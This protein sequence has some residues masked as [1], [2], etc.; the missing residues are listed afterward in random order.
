MKRITT[1]LFL[2]GL[3]CIP[4]RS[5]E[6]KLLRQPDINQNQVVFVYASDLWTVPAA[7]GIATRL[8]SHRGME[9][10]PKISPDG[11]W[12]AFSGEYN[13]SRQIFVIPSHGGL[14]RQLT[15][16][17]DVGPMPPRG[18]W[19]HI[20]LDWTPDSRQVL[21]RANRTPYGKRNG[22]YYLVSINGGL[23]TPLEIPEGG[24][25]GFSPE[26]N[27]ICYTPISREFRTWK[28]YRGGRA[29]D[30][31]TY[32][33]E[34]HRSRRLTTFTGS[35]QTPVWMGDKIYYCSDQDTRLNVF[36]FDI[37][38]GETRQLTRH[39]EFDCLWLSGQKGQLVYE[40]GGEIYRLEL[41]TGKNQK[42]PV[43][44]HTDN[45]LLLPRHQNVRKNIYSYQLSPTG[46]RALM[47]ARGDIYTVPA[48]H[49]VI[50]NLT[51]S[52]GIREI[53]PV[54]SPD[55]KHIAYYSDASGEYELYLKSVFADRTTQITRESTGWKNPPRWSPDSRYLLYSDRTLHLKYLEVESR[56]EKMIDRAWGHPI[57]DYR[58]SPDS[59][60]ITYAKD[61]PNGNDSLYIYSLEKGETHRVTTDEF[62]EHD[63]L[64]SRDGRYLFFLSQ[65]DFNL[66][67]SSYEFDYLYHDA[68]A[69]YY[70]PLT[71]TT[72]SLFPDR[73]D[74]ES[75]EKPSPE[76]KT[77]KVRLD[78]AG[79]CRRIGKF[80]LG[81]G[82][83]HSLAAVENGLL[84][85]KD[86]N[87]KKYDLNQ[88]KELD[89]LSGIQGYEPS[90]DG[91]K[92]LYSFAG[93]G[94][95]I[96][97]LD[98]GQQ[99]HP[100]ELDLEQMVMDIDPAR[101]W[102]QIFMDCWRIFRDWFYVQNLHN[103]NW[104]AVRDKY[105]ALVPYLGHRADL[106]F[107][108]GEMMAESNTGHCYVNWGD[109]PEIRRIPTG[110]LG[111]ELTPRPEVRRYQIT[112]IYPG[113]NW[114]PQRV[115]PLTLPGVF[116]EEGDYLIR[117]NGHEVTT[118][119]NPY[120]FLVDRVDR[121]TD[122]TV[123]SGPGRE[124]ERTYPIK[125]VASELALFYLD[126]VHT[127]RRMV[128]EM[129]GGRIGYI[130]VPDTSI[131]GNRELF[132]GMYSFHHKEA[133]IIDE[134][135]NGGGFI[136]DVMA[137]F[138]QRKTLSYWARR[139]LAPFKSPGIAH[140]GP[141]A[142]LINHYSSS[143]GDAFPYYFRKL[144]LG[145]IIGTRTW[146]GLV[147]ISGNPAFVDGGSV[148]VPTFG[149]Y[150]TGGNWVVEGVGVAP[151]I[152]VIDYPH[153]V[154]KGQD[155]ALEKAVE[156]LLKQLEK[157]PPPEVKTPRGPDRSRWIEKENGK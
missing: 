107:L 122:I 153:Q 155:P 123:S 119:D 110:L 132:R 72:P 103:V 85:M 112:R 93:D 135:Y 60:Y 19:D 148:A 20:P 61:A 69:I 151:D 118:D 111:A 9:I 1:V 140:D 95:G 127:R 102:R 64:F 143:G 75:L 88:R 44:I 36:S 116:V 89:I 3:L 80:P 109:L 40:N 144:K 68:T 115:S 145:T 146:G 133:L 125:P 129:S 23:E 49:G 154:A 18:G 130:H 105:L 43:Q 78:T 73:N 106:D 58:W 77:A 47:G 100:G 15:F 131:D 141:K 13:G 62:N 104:E 51:R 35:D 11:K 83:Y 29:A 137:Y 28:R 113:E 114:N 139:G 17:N 91:Q 39:R 34:K 124:K 134:R 63:P 121:L 70:L 82:N 31:W 87:L 97:G 12:I 71:R 30:I 53:F 33:L 90:F 66:A 128:K 59:R 76:T 55:K 46:K 156:V 10:F 136:P 84:F 126:W 96:T 38:S 99:G 52:Q 149:I 7:G 57:T 25:G 67:F 74:L 6:M 54:W 41:T 45:P 147:G 14:P 94:Y 108:L 98:P 24:L 101:E 37:T 65:R 120:R 32:D 152:E 22:R 27:R 86:Q 8:T 92:I 157:N 48:E 117:I 150:D 26:G 16:Y 81:N 79:I 142:M 21:F 50:R 138:L 42:I 5:G 56:T 2:I 4:G